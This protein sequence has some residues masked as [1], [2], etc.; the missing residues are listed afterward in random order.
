MTEQLEQ[1]ISS[2]RHIIGKAK[3]LQQ[4][5]IDKDMYITAE[6][7]RVSIAIHEDLIHKMTR[8]IAGMSAF[9][10]LGKSLAV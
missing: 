3:Q 1:M 6:G 9:E 7:F 8:I 4:E 5:A 2:S 10:P